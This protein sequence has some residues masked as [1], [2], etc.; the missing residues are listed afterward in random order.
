MTRILSTLCLTA[1]ALSAM[2]AQAQLGNLRDRARRAVENV[3]GRDDARSGR[4]LS[5]GP[6]QLEAS[7]AREAAERA[8]LE[9]SP[10]RQEAIALARELMTVFFAHRD[11]LRDLDAGYVR[12]LSEEDLAR[13]E[14]LEATFPTLQ[15]AM[16]PL[17]ERWSDGEYDEFWL[18][19]EQAFR[20]MEIEDADYMEVGATFEGDLDWALRTMTEAIADAATYRRE[21]AAGEVGTLRFQLETLRNEDDLDDY[22]LEWAA[23]IRDQTDL[24]LRYD[25]SNADLNEMRAE[26]IEL[27]AEMESAFRDQIATNRWPGHAGGAP[28]QHARAVLDYLRGDD[29]WGQRGDG[30]EVLAVAVR[31]DWRPVKHNLLGQVIQWGLPVVV[32]T[33]K[34]SWR[35]DF[36]AAQLYELTMLAPEGLPAPQ[37]PPFDAGYH[38]GL[39][40]QFV[41]LDRIPNQ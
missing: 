25:P 36:G 6:S 11:Q 30:Y 40:N 29:R 1:I 15:A 3:T 20:R 16:L 21:Q 39:S 23:R 34:P 35:D 5:D 41:A 14:A 12:E 37:R 27:V 26:T 2:P 4:R 8:A 18:N 13:I 31:G 38:V 10:E 28:T 33:T 19:V 9:A 22:D 32:A 7:R 24:A 17:A